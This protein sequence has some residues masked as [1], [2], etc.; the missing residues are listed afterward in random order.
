MSKED[1]EEMVDPSTFK[2]MVGSLRY[3]EKPRTPHY[4]T[5]KRILRYIKEAREL[6]LIYARNQNGDEAGLTGFTYVDWCG[7]KDDRKNTSGYV[8]MINES[9]ILWCSRKQIIV[10]LSTCEV[11][12]VVASMEA[13]Q[14]IWLAELLT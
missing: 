9:P 11:E 10:A 1:N 6:G 7:D 14:G 3:M 13:C 5:T 8:F 4:L 12:Y 2:P